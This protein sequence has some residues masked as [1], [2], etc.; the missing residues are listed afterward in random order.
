MAR[1]TTWTHKISKL[2]HLIITKDDTIDFEL[3]YIHI[4]RYIWISQHQ[5]IHTD[6]KSHT[7]LEENGKEE[8]ESI[9]DGEAPKL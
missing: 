8:R 6:F 2:S 3:L 1:D 4:H 9:Q 7:H 5:I